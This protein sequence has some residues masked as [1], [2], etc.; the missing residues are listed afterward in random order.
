ML[1]SLRSWIAALLAL[2]L[3]AAACSSSKKS[4]PKPTTT[5]ISKAAGR[6][7]VVF[8][9]ADDLDLREI[10]YLPSVERLI[11]DQGMALDDYFISNSLCC[12][13]RTTMLRG[14]YAHDTGVHS[15][16]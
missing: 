8:V 16:S 11:R 15:N 9:L 13:S 1:S 5:T 6:P 4:K 10:A 12:P 3:L 2:A 14:E 7:N